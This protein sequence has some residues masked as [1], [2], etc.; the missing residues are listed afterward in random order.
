MCIRDR[1]ANIDSTLAPHV[2]ALHARV[3]NGLKGL[4]KKMQRAERRKLKDESAQLEKLKAILFPKD[5]L[6][7]RLEN[8]VPYYA[9][10]GS[11]LLRLLYDN[12]LTLEQKFT[13]LH[14]QEK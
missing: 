14:L 7:E 11:A 6:Q 5:K 9:Q 10:Y 12:S 4:E 8:M 3:L 1:A 2:G 13:V